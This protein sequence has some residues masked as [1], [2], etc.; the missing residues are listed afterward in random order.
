MAASAG[1]GESTSPPPVG[2]RGGPPRPACVITQP[3]PGGHVSRVSPLRRRR[4]GGAW[5]TPLSPSPRQCWGLRPPESP[6]RPVSTRGPRP[7]RTPSGS[8]TPPL[9]GM[10]E[11]D[12]AQDPSGHVHRPHPPRVALGPSPSAQPSETET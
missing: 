7:P 10:G 11:V 8:P 9:D 2:T 1:A 6:L 4:G 12:A 5:V 3:R